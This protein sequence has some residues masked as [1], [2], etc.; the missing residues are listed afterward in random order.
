MNKTNP[1]P[2]CST[3]EHKAALRY[4]RR[5]IAAALQFRRTLNGLKQRNQAQSPS[6]NALLA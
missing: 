1:K 5:R 3:R 6:V 2:K 4:Q